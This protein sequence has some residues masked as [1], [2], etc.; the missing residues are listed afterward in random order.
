MSES[1]DDAF[2]KLMAIQEC[3]L[4]YSNQHQ[5][6]PSSLDELMPLLAE[7]G[8]NTDDLLKSTQD[9]SLVVFWDFKIHQPQST[10][11]V[12]V[13]Y[14][15]SSRGGNRMVMTSMGVSFM[16]DEEFYS[17]PF[18]PGHQAPAKPAN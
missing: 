2:G 6:G 3:Y 7:A 9:G 16:P 15:T 5:K 12:I 18:P 4:Q 17:A 1:Q 13:G 8:H 11:P 10:E 14:Q